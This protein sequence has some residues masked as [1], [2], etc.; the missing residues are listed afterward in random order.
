[1]PDAEP[2]HAASA[3]RSRLPALAAIALVVATIALAFAWAAGLLTPGKLTPE[4]LADAI[5]RSNDQVFPGYRRAHAKGICVSGYFQ[6]NGNG[7]ALS[8]APMLAAARTPFV[9][10]M[11]IGGGKPHGDDGSA[12]VRSMALALVSD[13][14]QEWRMAMTNFPFF[15]VSSVEA[16]HEQ[17]LA[18][19]PLPDTGKPDPERMKAFLARHPEAAR[20]AEWAKTAPWPTSFANTTYNGINTFRF[21]NREGSE[22]HVRWSMQPQTPFAAMTP[23]QREE[24]AEDFLS[25]DLID[26]LAGGPLSWDMLVSLA[27]PGDSITDPSQAWPAARQ[28]VN[29]GTVVIESTQPQ[30]TGPCRDLNFDPLVLP[31]GVDGSEDPILAARS[32]V[33]SPSFN[34]R[35]REIALGHAAEATGATPAPTQG[36]TP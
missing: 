11:S 28:Q 22:R 3:R 8:E 24:A 7:V 25:Q 33:Y 26:R 27:E 1:M 21:A 30:A 10:R 31:A 18:S 19:T 6:G 23:E 4:R 16:F 9:G 2:S 13:D 5:Q 17:V 12:R 14:G 36:S 15:A 29:V 35:Q 34:R 20:F 32:A